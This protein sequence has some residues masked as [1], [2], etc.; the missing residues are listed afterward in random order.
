MKQ[1]KK[2]I[3]QLLTKREEDKQ[4]Y[5][6]GYRDTNE[7]KELNSKLLDL[8][9]QISNLKE[10]WIETHKM[11]YNTCFNDILYYKELLKQ[12]NFD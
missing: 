5:I 8:N 1:T 9:R 12:K 11:D 3:K 4:W 6:H 7:Y 10:E 2:D